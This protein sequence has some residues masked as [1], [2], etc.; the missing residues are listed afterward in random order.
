LK[1]KIVYVLL[2]CESRIIENS[3][4]GYLCIEGFA[5][6]VTTIGR[7][8]AKRKKSQ[9]AFD[10]GVMCDTISI[11]TKAETPLAGYLKVIWSQ[12]HIMHECFM[13]SI[14]LLLQRK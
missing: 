5:V 13:D 6:A 3:H 12:L 9:A 11:V 4:T 2:I 1:K 8:T 7:T 10:S 14:E